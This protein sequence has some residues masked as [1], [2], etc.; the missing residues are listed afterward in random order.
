M[1]SFEDKTYD[2]LNVSGD[3]HC[4]FRSVA[5]EAP[6]YTHDQLRTMAADWI[7]ANGDKDADGVPLKLYFDLKKGETLAEYVKRLRSGMWGGSG[8]VYALSH[9]LN[10]RI[11]VFAYSKNDN[12]L[13]ES[14]DV[15]PVC[16]NNESNIIRLLHINNHYDLLRVPTN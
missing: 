3:G 11:K 12:N 4:L 9:T 13:T 8:E 5:M 14:M 10:R 1:S 6:P 7:L 16:Y 2:V 15:I